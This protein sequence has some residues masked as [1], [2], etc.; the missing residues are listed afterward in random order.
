MFSSH[1]SIA[2]ASSLLAAVLA[3]QEQQQQQQQPHTTGTFSTSSSTSIS[4]AI[5]GASRHEESVQKIKSEN[6]STSSML[7]LQPQVHYYTPSHH[8][9]INFHAFFRGLNSWE[10]TRGAVGRLVEYRDHDNV[11]E[12]GGDIF[13]QCQ[14]N[15]STAAY[16]RRFHE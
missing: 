16:T 7:L 1:Q 4:S 12:I 15:H 14:S 5:E 6:L 11:R 8:N 2:G 13:I 3:Q 10:W 9:A